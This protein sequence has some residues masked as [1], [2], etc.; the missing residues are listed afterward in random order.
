MVE[1]PHIEPMTLDK[2]E[3]AFDEN[4]NP[5]TAVQLLATAAEYF[6]DNMI[7]IETVLDYTVRVRD[8]L[9]KY[10]EKGPG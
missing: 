8:Y 2:A 6:E 5:E 3:T 4:P 10:A 1:M 7:S 9:G